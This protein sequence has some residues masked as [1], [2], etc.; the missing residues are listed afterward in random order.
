MAIVRTRRIFEA[1]C[2]GLLLSVSLCGCGKTVPLENPTIQV[3]ARTLDETRV[4]VKRAL[5]GRGWLILSE[6]PGVT[7]ARYTR[8]NVNSATIRVDY[9]T[10]DATI[11]LEDSRELLYQKYGD[12]AVI[13]KNYMRWVSYLLQDIQLN[14]VR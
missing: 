3:S 8:M 14:L 11:T 10:T 13:H 4:A 1:M 7:R 6:D 12:G 5:V 2:C 9:S